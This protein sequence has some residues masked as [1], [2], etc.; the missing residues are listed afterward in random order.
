MAALLA[1]M[2]DA[3]SWAYPLGAGH[4]FAWE[5]ASSIAG[6]PMGAI[7]KLEG[8]D[9]PVGALTE[10]RIAQNLAN[11]LSASGYTAGS[12]HLESVGAGM[13]FQVTVIRDAAGKMVE[14]RVPGRV[15]DSGFE[16]LGPP[17]SST[18]IAAGKIEHLGITDP[19]RIV[20]AGAGAPTD[21]AGLGTP[22]RDSASYIRDNG[23][24]SH[25][26]TMGAGGTISDIWLLQKNAGSNF[27]LEEFGQAILAANPG[28]NNINDVKPGQT[29][30]IPEKLGDSSITYH[31]AGGTRVNCNAITG[32]YH[33]VVPN[34]EGGQTVY[35]RSVDGDA[36]YTVRQV[37]TNEQG[38]TT[39]EFTGHQANLT[40]EVQVL[41][42]S[43]PN[44]TDPGSPD[45]PTGPDDQDG[46]YLNVIDL[47]PPEL[48]S[49]FAGG[50]A[51]GAYGAGTLG[52]F[53]VLPLNASVSF[54]VNEDGDIAGEINRLTNGDLQ[55]KNLY[56]EAV[57]VNQAGAVLSREDY[58][59]ALQAQ[60]DA[61]TQAQYSQAAGAIG[62]MNSIIGLQ[63]WEDMGDLQ[64]VAAVAS[65]YNAL[66][67][68][69]GG[70]ALP[71]DLGTTASVLGLLNA[72]DQGNMGSALYSGLSIAE[73]LTFDAAT[74]M[75][76][77]TETL[78]GNFLPG[79][80]LVLAL[81]SGDPVSI[82]AAVVNFIPGWGQ[83]ASVVVTLLGSM[84]ESDIPMKEGLAHAEWDAQGNTIVITDQDAE[85]GG[86]TAA[87]WM[88][89]IVAGL[90]A[91]LA[92]TRDA[93]G[94]SY[95]LI[96][97]LLPAIGYQYDA[98]GMNYGSA[99]GHMYLRWT[100]EQGSSQTRYYD[101]AG[102]RADGTGETLAGDFMAHAQGAM[103]P[104]WQ[105][106]TVLAHWQQGQGI[107]LPDGQAS[108][109]QELADGIHQTL[110][111]L[112]LELPTPPTLTSS[113][114]DIDGD[115]Y[116]EKTQWLAAN[117][118]ILAIDA[119]GD[120]NIG[121][122]ELL[123]L[124]DSALNSL[125]WLDA[126]GDKQINASDPAFGAL[127]LWMDV[128]SDGSSS[129]ETQ[130]LS[131]AGISAIDFGSNP[132][133]V[134]RADGS[135]S[136]LTA[137]TLHGDI[138]GVRY[139]A[140]VGGVLEAKERGE[141]VLHAVNTRAFDGQAGHMQGGD[142]DTDGTAEGQAVLI[143]AQDA[144]L[145]STTARTL[146]NRL[147]FVPIAAT[148]QAQAQR[149][150]T[151]AMVRSAES[152]LFGAGSGAA[153]LAALALGLG[154][155]QW[156]VV[157]AA[158]PGPVQADDSAPGAPERAKAAGPYP[159]LQAGATIVR[160]E[161]VQAL[162]QAQGERL[163]A[164][165][166]ELTSLQT[167]QVV[168]DVQPTLGIGASNQAPA[169]SGRVQV[170]ID[171]VANE[172]SPAA[173]AQAPASD[174]T[175]GLS[176]TLQGHAGHADG[177][178]DMQLTYPTVM[179]ELVAGT[180]DIGLRISADL[181][182]AN[183]R[184]L[185]AGDPSR[186]LLR[187][188]AVGSPS[189][190]KVALRTNE[191]GG[192]EVVFIPETNYHGP[193]SFSYTVTDPY[194]LSTVATATLEIAPVNDAPT[195]VA[196]AASG[197]ED[198]TLMFTAASLLANDFDVDSE[199]DGDVLRIT[200]VGLAE[201]GQV[202][203]QADGNIRF[204]PDLDYNGPAQFSYWVADRSEAAMAAA[205][206]GA[207]P[208]G[209]GLETRGT[210]HLTV[211]PV[212]D[213]PVATG[214]AI[215]SDEDIV[216]AINPALLLAND[217][218][219][220]TATNG[221][222]LTVS[223]VSGAQHG[224]VVLLA[225]GTVQFTPERDYFG[226]AS[227]VYTVDD[228]HGGQVQS[229]AVV[230]LAPVNDVPVVNDELLMGKRNATYTLSQAALL[231]ND[232]DLETPGGLR[233]VA[234]QGVSHGTAVLNANGSVTFAPE[235]GYAGRGRFEY[236]VQDADG[237]RAMAATE[238]DFSSI[239]VNPIA[240]D[241]SFVGY[242][243][244]AFVIQANQLLANDADP[245][246]SGLAALTVDA[247]RHASHGT[248]SLQADGSI[249][250]DPAANF[251]GTASFEYRS[252]DGEG[253]QT[254][255]TAY[256]NVQ[257]VNDAPVI[258]DIWY[259]TPI[260]GTA[261]QAAGYDEWGQPIYASVPI[262]SESQARALLAN[263]L[264]SGWSGSY[265]NSGQLRPVGFD[266]IDS[267]VTSMPASPETG[268]QPT[269]YLQD[270]PY[271]QNGRVIAYDPDGDSAAITVSIGGGP[272]HGHAWANVVAPNSAQAFLTYDAAPPYFGPQ[273]GAW[274]YFSHLGDPYTGSDPFTLTVTDAQGASTSAMVYAAH[275]GSSA[276]GGG[277]C[278]IVVDLN[279]DGIALIRPEDSDI[280]ADVNG[281][282]WRERIGWAA[283]EDGV[284]AFD[285]NGDGRITE[286]AEVSFVGYK[287]GARTD[288]DGLAAF[289]TD[290]D[291]RL[292][293]GDAAWAQFG[294]LRDANGN[295]RQDEGE[296]VSLDQ[297]GVTAIALQRQGSPRLNNGNVVFGTADVTYADGR[298]GQAGD[299]MFAGENVPLPAAVLAVLPPLPLPTEQEEAARLTLL[300][301]QYG[302]LA[303]GLSPALGFVDW[304][305]TSP[306]LSPAEAMA[307][308]LEQTDH[309]GAAPAGKP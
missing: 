153:P 110:Q 218:D 111:A 161:P 232:T 301:S 40:A 112:S 286:N 20:V 208:G 137:Q 231:A 164:T 211:L 126:N 35:S 42:Q 261:V 172:L 199:V 69:S 96:P 104:A 160:A 98:D 145:S 200:R 119:N 108:L 21:P 84:F 47:P 141:T 4:K 205:G 68:M 202:F 222:V 105:V 13:A 245:D 179:G 187:I 268:E 249:R 302:A 170:A 57:Y 53:D 93:A 44:S 186:P 195:P 217:S 169:P 76:F 177:G 244:V 30:Y 132:P 77:V 167:G 2:Q 18:A 58:Q 156:P 287:A 32:E 71:G 14:V 225:D 272:Q 159:D 37:S 115:G 1:E 133:A 127:R 11:G 121:A 198:T 276:G 131:Q 289:D 65:I 163:D 117:Q 5:V 114:I 230:N 303:E 63:H 243:D 24:G 196:D 255:A 206:G 38:A 193:A 75:G 308:A 221:Q 79:L 204:V 6:H 43:P 103:A 277:K 175:N 251:Y 284:L 10:Q 242:E 123:K 171:S 72:L 299:V 238:I 118:Q 188:S 94:N 203:L 27:S 291:G 296:L 280:F 271:R 26:V 64:R 256:L 265:Y 92:A 246:A 106:Q 136:L 201:H 142:A 307:S 49:Y 183:D 259:G 70:N 99:P 73:N 285:A 83:V 23:G 135:R 212:N 237:G 33:M 146:A 125:S 7:F 120:G 227:F 263:G 293:A 273:A 31:Y 266:P 61:Q 216:L 80:N 34:A 267:T 165:R 292:N 247:V 88:N 219:V 264:L 87:G 184:T 129:G 220:D 274:Q 197:D 78:G 59:Q 298:T 149:E 262:A 90:Q 210:M 3:P 54:L 67:K 91:Q 124:G 257:S 55:I 282:G 143:H 45:L 275:Q 288:L 189:H 15:S 252:N 22:A 66:D 62:L 41:P 290:G 224:A 158:S 174:V 25:S 52:G 134:I 148:T 180:E 29:L 154:A 178:G 304:T 253:G 130:G 166:I 12:V 229:T 28:V 215:A 181:L 185:N 269:Y 270:D 85:G 235:P 144:R 168:D 9:N 248:V 60:Q 102:N 173:S 138:L 101:G 209:V 278:P 113:L 74:N 36:G 236:V 95:A 279:G 39:F 107:H 306:T 19:A 56:G 228:G 46:N 48:A 182:L 109:P 283:D 100:D 128:N 194:G 223:A 147:A 192:T 241:D 8:Y 176:A 51:G 16:A 258:E 233:I 50:N 17:I 86:A 234:V 294:V 139:T 116:L 152:A 226:P 89:S 207:I 295:G 155:M 81:D 140:T 122:G 250:F 157:A 213:L 281:D 309:F 150:V 97:H 297:L 254:W 190:G 214:E 151:A 305:Q 82:L 239:N 162:R 191:A 300:M 260:Y 240:T